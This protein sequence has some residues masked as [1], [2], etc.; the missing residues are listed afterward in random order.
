[1]NNRLTTAL[2]TLAAVALTLTG[3]KTRQ[4][5]QTLPERSIV[6]LYDND[7]HCGIDGYQKMAGLRDAI[8]DTA[9][10]T[11]TSSGDFL[12]GGTAGAISSGQYIVDIMKEM[13]YAA[14][15]LGNHEFDYKVPRMFQLI[16]YAKLPVTC[17]NL[18]EYNTKEHIYV[19]YIIKQL[20]NKKVAFVGATTPTTITTEAYAF[21]EDDGE[22]KYDLSDGL[23]YQ[24]VQQAA[25]DA[26]HAGADYVIVLSHLGEAKNELNCDSHGLVAATRGIDAVLDGHTHSIVPHAYVKNLDGKLVPVTQTGTKFQNIGKLV[27]TPSGQVSTQLIDPKTVTAVNARVKAVTDSITALM[28]KETKRPICHSD[29]KLRILDDKGRQEVRF[30]ETNAGDLVADAFLAVTEADIAMTNGGGIRSEL[31]PGDLTYGDV[32]SLLPYDNYLYV[33]EVTGAELMDLLETCCKYAPEE[34]GDFPQV[35]GIRFA[36]DMKGSP[37][38]QNLE[39]QNKLTGEYTAVSPSAKYTLA[40][41]DYCITGGGFQYKLRGCKR[42]KESVC[43][44]NDALI[45]YVQQTLKGKLPERYAKPQG[46]IIIK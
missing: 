17:V 28:E 23:V 37:R 1:M 2:L 42:L 25:D 41:T 16:N 32:L 3:C 39:I 20:G 24:Q 38:I 19:P 31:D 6:V 15:T 40:T 11:V 34:N 29:Y 22:Q 7:V 12:Q 44:Y 26:R 9:W 33:I 8:S 14:V 10:V 30:A 21:F 35:A 4:L 36:M 27:I 45:Q 13:D 18:R 46:R 43:L 5:A